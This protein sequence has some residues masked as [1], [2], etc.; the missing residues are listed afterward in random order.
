VLDANGNLMLQGYYLNGAK[1][2]RW[3]HFRA[4]GCI[5]AKENFAIG[6]L[7][8][9]KISYYDDGVIR[10]KAHYSNDTRQGTTF[11]NDEKGN[12]IADYNYF[13]NLFHG[14]QRTW[15]PYRKQKSESYL[16]NFTQHG[17]HAEHYPQGSLRTEGECSGGSKTGKWIKWSADGS[18]RETKF[19]AK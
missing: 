16:E 14:I 1:H 10:E 4:G 9:Y 8:G 11:W 12:P 2:G 19:Y 7:N 15:H 17:K 13:A 5:T 3:L 18:I 6:K